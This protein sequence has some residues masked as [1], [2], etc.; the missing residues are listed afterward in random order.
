MADARD[1]KSRDRM[2]VRVRSPSPPPPLFFP[3]VR[4]APGPPGPLREPRVVIRQ[5][6][7]WR[8]WNLK[9]TFK[10]HKEASCK[11]RFNSSGK[12]TYSRGKGPL[13]PGFSG[14]KKRPP[15]KRATLSNL[16]WDRRVKAEPVYRTIKQHF[17]LTGSLYR[18]NFL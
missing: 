5:N 13:D 2:V 6:L 14:G 15:G 16:P 10:E 9:N 3:A 7:P 8:S 17:I 11:P 12:L 1:L 4:M 18:C